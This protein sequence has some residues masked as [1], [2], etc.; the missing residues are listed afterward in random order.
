MILIIMILTNTH[1]NETCFLG[2]V[3]SYDSGHN[4]GRGRGSDVFPW[5]NEY[6]TDVA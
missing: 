5:S 1:P 4:R 3:D 6:V 2:E